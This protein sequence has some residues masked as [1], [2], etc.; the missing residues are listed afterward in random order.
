MSISSKTYRAY[1]RNWKV[2]EQQIWTNSFTKAVRQNIVPQ[3]T[4]ISKSEAFQKLTAYVQDTA[5]ENVT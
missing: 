1:L 3:K 5:K 2:K 4:T